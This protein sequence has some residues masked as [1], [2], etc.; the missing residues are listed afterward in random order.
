VGNM[1]DLSGKCMSFDLILPTF[2]TEME[3]WHDTFK[4]ILSV[5]HNHNFSIPKMIVV[6]DLFKL[7]LYSYV[8]KDTICVLFFDKKDRKL[9]LSEL[10][11]MMTR[12]QFNPTL[13]IWPSMWTRL[14]H[15][16][17]LETIN[18]MWFLGKRESINAWK[19]ADFD[20]FREKEE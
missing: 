5:E 2:T 14:E 1:V 17:C 9:S 10:L 6:N 7:S 20:G 13:F 11:S 15:A 12:I 16:H 18:N 8:A 19:K 4:G 3:I